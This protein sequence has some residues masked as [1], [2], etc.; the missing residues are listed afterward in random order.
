MKK[1]ILLI[2][3]VL[4]FASFSFTHAE[5]KTFTK[6]YTYQA[7]ELD[8][9]FTCRTIALEQV[10]RLLFE[11]IGSYLETYTEVQNFQLNKHQII[12]LTAGILSVKV[13]DEKWNDNRYWLKESIMVD[14][15]EVIRKLDDI[16]ENSQKMS[17]LEENRANADKTLLAIEGLRNDIETLKSDR[18]KMNNYQTTVNELSATDW[19]DQGNVLYNDGEKNQVLKAYNKAIE[20]TPSYA[21][22]YYFRSKLYADLGNYHQALED[23]NKAIDLEPYDAE[24]FNSRGTIY[25]QNLDNCELAIYDYNRAIELDHYL[26][27]P[28][29]NRA[30]CHIKLKEYNEAILDSGK[31]IELC[32]TRTNLA[33]A[34][35]NRGMA[36]ELVGNSQ[37]AVKDY[38]EA[39]KYHRQS[40]F[41]FM[42]GKVYDHLGDKESSISDIKMAARLN[43]KEAQDYLRKQRIEW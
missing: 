16:R 37:Q 29:M 9:E 7:I 4:L 10:K 15:N 23:L 24:N 20:L 40:Q 34:Y 13:M 42:R 14:P 25:F 38:S 31:A 30:A 27:T 21:N 33:T 1:I 22:P 28:Y 36:Y 32:K 18:M 12:V 5:L 17:K 41:Y 11:E 26:G 39:I 8:S 6:E 35:F 2:V 3:A 43:N 19:V